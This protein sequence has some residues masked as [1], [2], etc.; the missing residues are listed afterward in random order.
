MLGGSFIV[1]DKRDSSTKFLCKSSPEFLTGEADM[2]SAKLSQ[3]AG[4]LAV[5]AMLGGVGTA[6]AQTAPA[7]AVKTIGAPAAAAKPEIVPSLF[8]S[9]AKNPPNAIVSVLSK[10]GSVKDCRRGP[11]KSEARWRQ[12]EVQRSDP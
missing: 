5:M 12:A 6:T 8:D 9:F 7:P 1:S 11:E 10:D 2:K 3:I 4:M